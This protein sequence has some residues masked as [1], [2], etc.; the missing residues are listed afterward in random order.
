MEN[1]TNN[2][3]NTTKKVI[4]QVTLSRL[5]A[6]EQPFLAWGYSYLKKMELVEDP[7]NPGEYIE[8]EVQIKIP[9]KSVGVSEV[10]D[11][12]ARK[13]PTPPT[14]KDYVKMGTEE[15]KALGL[16]HPKICI[17]ENY[18]D[19]EYKEALR[20]HGQR[21]VYAAVLAGL[22]MDIEDADGRL[23]VEANGHNKPTK[24]VDEDRAI[25]IL[26]EQGISNAQFDQLYEDIQ[27]LT[28]REVAR[29]DRE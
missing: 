16:T 6:G 10:S 17:F 26:K 3:S 18:S 11:R 20:K 27:H 28:Q 19:P 7:E 12:I 22:A 24:I 1:E 15:A 8:E 5:K 4:R 14:Y 23:V 13:A 25:E 9:I 29:V 21:T 2:G